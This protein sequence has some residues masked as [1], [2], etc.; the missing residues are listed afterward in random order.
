LTN[1]GKIKLAIYNNLGQEMLL[2]ANESAAAG[3]FTKTIDVS[4]LPAGVYFC[5]LETGISTKIQ[6]VIIQH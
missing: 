6:R 2:I 4:T 1:T 3:S 5:K